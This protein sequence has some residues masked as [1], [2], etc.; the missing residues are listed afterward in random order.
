VRP[1][2][3]QIAYQVLKL[4]ARLLGDAGIFYAALRLGFAQDPADLHHGSDT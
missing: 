2:L 3:N 1:H 4:G